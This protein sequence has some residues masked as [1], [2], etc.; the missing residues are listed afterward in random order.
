MKLLF[1]DSEKKETFLPHDY[2]HD[3]FLSYCSGTAAKASRQSFPL[4]EFHQSFTFF[5]DNRSRALEGII[6]VYCLGD[7]L[8]S[9]KNG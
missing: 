1:W 4:V 6:D 3:I 9:Q 8:K 7:Y 5:F 2:C